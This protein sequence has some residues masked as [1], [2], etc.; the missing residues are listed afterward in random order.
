[1]KEFKNNNLKILVIPVTFL[2]LDFNFEFLNKLPQ[3]WWLKATHLFSYS[4]GGQK[5]GTFLA[6]LKSRCG[7]PQGDVSLPF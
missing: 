6:S 4:S 7:V 1:M 3:I 5:S 2:V